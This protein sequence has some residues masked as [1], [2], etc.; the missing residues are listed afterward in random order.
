MDRREFLAKAGLAATWA[1]IAV[2]VAG[3]GDEDGGAGPGGG[4]DVTG[5][6]DA[7][8]GHAVTITEAQIADG[9]AVDLSLDGPGDDHVHMVSLS[10]AQVMEIGAGT[11]VAVTSTTDDGHSHRVTFN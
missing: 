3:C 6:I 2:R 11:R 9:Q 5:A 10:S 7:N 4:G 8:H 1:G